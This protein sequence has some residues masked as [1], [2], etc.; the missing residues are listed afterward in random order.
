MLEVPMA[1]PDPEFAG[2]LTQPVLLTQYGNDET[3]I[4]SAALATT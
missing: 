3:V 1:L 4:G 2:F